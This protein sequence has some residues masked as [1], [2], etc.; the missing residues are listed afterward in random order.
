MSGVGEQREQLR[1]LLAATQQVV[2]GDQPVRRAGQAAIAVEAGPDEPVVGQVVTGEQRRDPVV[3]RGL[4]DGPGRRQ[5]AEDRPLDP[6]G[7]GHRGGLAIVALGQPPAAWLD[8]DEAALRRAGQLVA[9]QGEQALDRIRAQVAGRGRAPD[10]RCRAGRGVGPVVT[11]AIRFGRVVGAGNPCRHPG[12]APTR[13]EAIAAPPSGSRLGREGRGR[14]PAELSG[15]IEPDQ[16]L[17]EQSL[18]A[19]RLAAGAEG[20]DRRL[21][22]RPGGIGRRERT[23]VELLRRGEQAATRDHVRVAGAAGRR[24]ESDV[25]PRARAGWQQAP[26]RQQL[27]DSGGVVVGIGE[28]RAEH[29]VAGGRAAHHRR[30]DRLR[31][32]VDELDDPAVAGH[33]RL[34]RLERAPDRGGLPAPRRP[35]RAPASASIGSSAAASRPSTQAVPWYAAASRSRLGRIG[36]WPSTSRTRGVDAVRP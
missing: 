1:V 13:R 30:D 33:D 19:R 17:A 2:A 4:G 23:L 24:V 8:L 20:L 27:H 25:R 21:G 11:A 28:S 29:A 35:E 34:D 31:P 22:H 32:A 6:I 10:P 12:H 3:E 36:G 9:D 26:G 18:V 7:E 15:P 16:D 5:E 14:Q